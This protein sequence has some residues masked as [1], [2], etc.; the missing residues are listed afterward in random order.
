MK[1]FNSDLIHFQQLHDYL[2][3]LDSE[4]LKGW[5]YQIEANNPWFTQE[6]VKL[7]LAGIIELLEPVALKNWSYY[8]RKYSCCRFS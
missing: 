3:E 7:A 2:K 1:G 6:N 8:G 4:E 5:M